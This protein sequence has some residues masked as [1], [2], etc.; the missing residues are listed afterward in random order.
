MTTRIAL[1]IGHNFAAGDQGATA[2]GAT[3]AGTTKAIIDELVKQGMPGFEIIKV[4][5]KLDIKQRN[6]WINARSADLH[7]YLELHLDAATPSATGV[8]TFFVGGNTWAEGEARQFQQ[9][10]TRI[11]GLK[12]RGVKPDTT[13]RW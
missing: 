4:P 8:T 6:A 1:G 5:E 7:A 12:G 9:G 3:E 13:N 2:N 11:T 10:Y